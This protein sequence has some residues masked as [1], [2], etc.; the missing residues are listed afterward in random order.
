M[1]KLEEL[2]LKLTEGTH[3][4]RDIKVRRAATESP[5][6]RERTQKYMVR[7]RLN[8]EAADLPLRQG[9]TAVAAICT[10][11]GR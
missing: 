8:D 9:S 5:R 1:R 3:S 2:M 4:E 7:L 11:H 10:K 6:A